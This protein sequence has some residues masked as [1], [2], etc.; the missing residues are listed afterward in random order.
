MS[1]RAAEPRK[2]RRLMSADGE[3]RG[4][5][6]GPLDEAPPRTGGLR[7][8]APARW[9]SYA[10]ALVATLFWGLSF[11]AVHIALE[12]L[13]PFG[14]VWM[15]S[16]LG[17]LILLG[18]LRARGAALLPARPDRP[19]CLLLG[20]I[21]GVHLLAQTL[22]QQWT[23]AARSGWI[24]AFIPVV[25]ALLSAV[26]LGRRLRP[27]GWAGIAIATTGVL[28][29][30]AAPPDEL[31]RAGWGDLLML[32]TCFLWASYTL[33]SFGPMQRSG[34]LAVTAFSMGIAALPSLAAA[35]LEGSRSWPATG[36][37]LAALVFL[38]VGASAVANWAFNSAVLELGPERAAAFQ[39][40]QPCVTLAG[41]AVLLDEPIGAALFQSG[42]LVL[43]GVWLV[44]RSKPIPAVSAR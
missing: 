29:L 23:T 44:Q 32:S 39:Y 15:R 9:Q 6:R 24:I 40:L 5:P 33:L 13:A 1:T 37:S 22:A 10:K 21:L 36:Q 17:A 20:A 41:S 30:T 25:V 7:A 35:V 12:G 43:L 28:A 31:A 16:A 42:P 27:I 19:R 38:G 3:P 26:L 11:V 4:S 34:P 18:V 14:V 2:M 8:R